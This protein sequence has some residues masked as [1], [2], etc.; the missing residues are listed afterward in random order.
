MKIPGQVMAG[1]YE[2][3]GSFLNSFVRNEKKN[4]G[5]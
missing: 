4:S 5:K 3:T 2:E 1:I